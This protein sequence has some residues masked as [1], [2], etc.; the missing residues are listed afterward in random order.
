M[1]VGGGEFAV[2]EWSRRLAKSGI[3][4]AS[5]FDTKVTQSEN[6]CHIYILLE[7]HLKCAS[8]HPGHRS[9]STKKLKR[10]TT[11][12]LV[13]CGLTVNLYTQCQGTR[14]NLLRFGTLDVL[15]DTHTKVHLYYST[16]CGTHTHVLNPLHNGES[17]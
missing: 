6:E 13:A 14:M 3:V 8:R 7:G 11:K 16:H 9:T 15:I 12:K 4:C 2:M 10:E 5:L 17:F 1:N